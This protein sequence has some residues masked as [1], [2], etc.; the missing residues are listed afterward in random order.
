MGACKAVSVSSPLHR[1]L[2][3]GLTPD[4]TGTVCFQMTWKEETSNL[5]GRT[6]VASRLVPLHLSLIYIHNPL[7]FSSGSACSGQAATLKSNCPL[8]TSQD[9]LCKLHC[10]RHASLSMILVLLSGSLVTSVILQQSF[11]YVLHDK[12]FS[13]GPIIENIFLCISTF[14]RSKIYTTLHSKIRC[15]V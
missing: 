4:R 5:D 13:N 12:M 8:A 2:I 15:L 9:D 3:I 1:P 10:T 7:N 6:N 14:F 11:M